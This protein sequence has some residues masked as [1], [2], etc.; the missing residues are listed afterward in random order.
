MS[1]VVW[2]FMAGITVGVLAAWVAIWLIPPGRP[3]HPH[4]QTHECLTVKRIAARIEHER[5]EAN[6]TST[7]SVS[8][9]TRQPAPTGIW[10]V[11]V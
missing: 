9:Q 3:T 5:L 1:S 10:S 4:E 6:R 7:P 11:R 2:P 8:R